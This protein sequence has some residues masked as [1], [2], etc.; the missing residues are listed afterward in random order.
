M[1]P[2]ILVVT[3]LVMIG[4][5]I[6]VM[7]LY[8]TRSSGRHAAGAS[9]GRR[10]QTSVVAASSLDA[11]LPRSMPNLLGGPS[12]IS[13]Y[14]MED[15]AEVPTVGD[16]DPMIVR[17][18]LRATWYEPPLMDE[19]TVVLDGQEWVGWF[20]AKRT[21]QTPTVLDPDH[22][23]SPRSSSAGHRTAVFSRVPAGESGTLAKA[24]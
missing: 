6:C 3:G 1:F 11:E 17:P 9:L 13:G 2:L 14:G 21:D 18:Y 16:E 12:L 10:E 5:I 24:A 8:Y 20:N 19:M 22:I 15:A 23:D 7:I 4:S